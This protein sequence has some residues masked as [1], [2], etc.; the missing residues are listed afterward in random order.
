MTT[1][2]TNIYLQLGD[3]I[4]IYAP[5]NSELN[6]HTFIIEYIDN[7]KI[8]ITSEDDAKYVLNIDAGMR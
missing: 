8:K 7:K 2:S 6:Q 3:I 4:Q 5:S 1:Q